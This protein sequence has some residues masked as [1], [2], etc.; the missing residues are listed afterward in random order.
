LD[1]GRK[2]GVE[3][4]RLYNINQPTGHALPRSITCLTFEFALS[5]LS[6]PVRR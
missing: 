3:V 1:G 2:S 4:A 6:S 5:P